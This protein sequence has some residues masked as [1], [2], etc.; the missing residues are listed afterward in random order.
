[1]TIITEHKMM[2]VV[3]TVGYRCDN[4]HKD[5]FHTADTL[6]TQEFLHIRLDGGFGSVFG[7]LSIIEA[8]ICQ[9]CLKDV[10]GNILKV[11]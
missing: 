5:Y 2:E 9:H 7:D 1:M 4:C 6:E 8:D 10:W 3:S 11:S